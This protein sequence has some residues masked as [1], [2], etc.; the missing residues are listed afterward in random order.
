MKDY[1]ER[2]NR[3]SRDCS[4][5]EAIYIQTIQSYILS[6]RKCINLKELLEYLEYSVFYD[7]ELQ[8]KYEKEL[9]DLLLTFNH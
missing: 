1:L 6:N 5:D 9:S 3:R 7:E 2:L 8:K 4:L